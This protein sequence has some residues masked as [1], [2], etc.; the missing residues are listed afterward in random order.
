MLK[1][2]STYI[3][4]REVPDEISLCI[5]ISGCKNNCK[6]CHSPFLR[7][8]TG[9]SLNKA[10][11]FE[12]INHNNGITCVAFMGGDHNTYKI[13]DLANIIKC[14]FTNLKVAWY[15]GNDSIPA[16]INICKFLFDYI[17]IGKYDENYG[18]LDSPTTNQRMYMV[19]HDENDLLVD[20]TNKFNKQYETENTN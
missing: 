16:D 19:N 3:G 4:F 15:S 11:L 13:I 1:Y 7:D 5:N 17:K 8:N 9:T 20:I 12:L 10:T 6:G 14:E 2:H 18:P